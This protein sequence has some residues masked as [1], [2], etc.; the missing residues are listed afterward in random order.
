VAETKSSARGDAPWFEQG[1][2]GRTAEAEIACLIAFAD[3][4]PGRKGELR[5]AHVG[6]ADRGHEDVADRFRLDADAPT[7]IA[8]EVGEIPA[9]SD[10]ADRPQRAVQQTGWTG[11][12]GRREMEPMVIDRAQ[13]RENGGSPGESPCQFG[14]LQEPAKIEALALEIKPIGGGEMDEAEMSAIG[15]K[16][17][18]IG[19]RIR[20]TRF[21]SELAE[22]EFIEALVGLRGIGEFGGIEGVLLDER[23]D[24]RAA[25]WLIHAPAVPAGEPGAGR[26]G[27]QRPVAGPGFVGP[28]AA[29]LPRKSPRFRSGPEYRCTY[30]MGVGAHRNQAALG[31]MPFLRAYSKIPPESMT[32]RTSPMA[33]RA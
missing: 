6:G 28:N 22:E 11:H 21:R 14:V 18:G 1:E 33:R 17:H 3:G 20:W 5:A 19:I 31:I 23:P 32:G 7:A 9:Q 16:R 2:N 27:A 26:Q 25:G 30:R 24:A 15:G 8:P 4:L 12:A 29:R 13:P 10:G